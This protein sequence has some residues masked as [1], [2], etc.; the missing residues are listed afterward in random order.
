MTTKPKRTA[1]QAEYEVEEIIL[2]SKP[3][4]KR[5]TFW[6]VGTRP[7]ICHAWSKKAKDEMLSKQ[8]KQT[9]EGKD[10]RDPKAD[11]ISSLYEMGTD[12]ITGKIAYGFPATG[13]KKAI[14]SIAHKDKGIAKTSVMEAVWIDHEVVRV[15][16]ALAEAIC[17]MPL[18][19][20]YGSDP[21][22]REDMVRVGAGLNKTA[23][24]AYR[25]QFTNW[26]MKIGL[27]FN[28][29]TISP[30]ALGF[31]FKHAGASVGLGEWRNEKKGV[32]GAFRPADLL[33]GR[34]WEKFSK[35]EGPLPPQADLDET[36]WYD[37]EQEEA[38]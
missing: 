20:I 27:R 35:G 32:F 6:L 9:K 26:A 13:V 7:I 33:E 18:V 24:L 4:F 16:P 15:M 34:A 29:V 2:R 5:A 12:K 25:G 30:D 8:R 21:E 11:F 38:A 37:D 3:V 28:P 36:N 10:K 17:D 14:C 31:L 19:R 23:S 22:M 1:P